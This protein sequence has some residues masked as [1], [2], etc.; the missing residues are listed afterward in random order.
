[1]RPLAPAA[2][3]RRPR[4]SAWL[5]VGMTLLAPGAGLAS[6]GVIELNQVCATQTGCLPSDTPGFPITLNQRG[7]YR[8]TSDLG[9]S[10]SNTNG[11]EVR[12]DDVTV[13]LNGF[14]I[15][16]PNSV[17]ISTHICTAPGTGKGIFGTGVAAAGFV[18]QNGRVRGMGSDGIQVDWQNARIERVIVERNCGTGITLGVAGLVVDSQVR[19]NS[20]RGIFVGAASRVRDSIADSN[21]DTGILAPGS[22][23]VT[24]CVATANSGSGIAIGGTGGMAMGNIAVGNG[25]DGIVV[26][27]GGTVTNNSVAANTGVGIFAPASAGVGLN[28]VSGN[29]SSP[30]FGGVA[31]ACNVLDGVKACP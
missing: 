9:I 1:M 14:T 31:I 19:A 20:G 26:L 16:G 22:S 24:G 8:L 11:I 10:G 13:D 23:V 7:S 12:S 17:P 21:G 4:L 3:V 6:D 29:S 30:I 25:F 18:A 28:T 5:I 15:F 2:S 27:G